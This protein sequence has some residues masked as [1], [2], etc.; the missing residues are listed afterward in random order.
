MKLSTSDIRFYKGLIFANAL[1]PLLMVVWDAW[2][3]QLAVNPIESVLRT[4]GTMALIMLM[5]TLCI[6][7][8]RRLLG[9]GFLIV[10]RRM[11]GLFAFFYV[12]LHFVMYFVFDRSAQWA[13]VW[14]DTLD[15][16]FVWVGMLCLLMLIPLAVTSTHGMIKRLGAKRWLTLHKMVYLIA[17]GGVIHYYLIVKS[18]IIWPLFFAVW[19]ALLLGYRLLHT[20]R[21]TAV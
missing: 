2:H 14:Q 19:L 21:K 17:V 10:Y 18:D 20:W 1:L 3:G 7:P 6:T 13:K 4:L 9:W 12:C 15:R 11:L 5:L 8:L 16:P